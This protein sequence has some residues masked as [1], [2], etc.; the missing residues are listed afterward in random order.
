M[1]TTKV[2]GPPGSG[3]TTFLL[4]IVET[5]LAGG[6]R[7]MEIGYFA[8]TKKAATEARDRAIEKFPALNP[9]T[10]FPF[11][12]TLHSLAYRCLGISTKDMMSTEHYREFALEAGIELAIENGDE[13]FAVKADHP[14]LNEINIARIRGMDLKTH[15]NLSKMDIEWYHF[16]YV[17]R[18]YRHYKTSRN[19]LDFTDLLEHALLNPERLPRLEMTIIDEAQDLS[20]LQWRLVEALAKRS[21]RMFL[22][23]DDDQCQPA[24][25]KVLTT[26][27]EVSIEALDPKR[28]R[29]ICYDRRGSYVVG[30]KAGYAFKVAQ[31][32][33]TGRLY[34]VSSNQNQSSYTENHRCLVRWRP[35]LDVA[36]LRVVYLM[37]KGRHFRIGQCQ[38]FRADGCV[39]AWVRAHLE[40]AEKMWFLKVVRTTE[41]AFFW[42]NH[43]SYLYGIPQTVFKGASSSWQGVVD[44]LHKS[45]ETTGPASRMLADLGLCEQYPLY[46]RQ[47]ISAR[48]GGSQIFE[49]RACNLLPEAMLLASHEDWSVTWGT[50]ELHVGRYIGK[51]Y[52]LDVDKHH[53]YFAD[54][55]L[56][57]NCIYSW[58]G[59]DV[60]S[61][62]NFSGTVKVLD[63]SF[64]VPSK[65]HA[66]ANTVVTRIKQRQPK[67]WKAREEVGSISYYN[68]YSQVDI[69]HGNWLILA[70]ANYML[71]DMHD[72]I[73]SQGLLFERQGQRSVSENI[74]VAVLGWEKLRKGGEVPYPVVKMVYKYLDGEL[75]KH[76]HKM[77]RTA[78]TTIS[79]TL[80]LLKEK[81]G[82]L[83]SEIWHKVLTKISADRRDYLISLLRR[84]TRL[85]GHVPIKLSTI[86]GAKGGEADNVLLLSDLSTRF[87]KDYDKNS[88]DINR[89]L[90]V[91]ITRAKQTLHI[92]LPK[93]EQKGFRL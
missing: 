24:G 92:V 27:G 30:R 84:N 68:D 76:G 9:D 93:N 89:L 71:T 14:I 69:S 46:D 20:R 56:T 75:I 65:I 50:F 52:S 17:E 26:E 87:A 47:E 74:L 15:Y 44:T 33:Y 23:G 43:L 12:R 61:F 55:I 37:Q 79:Y 57:N 86:H 45:L 90:Y 16:E 48:R 54:G 67:V 7:P 29:L 59:A 11:F 1:N 4:S 53:N 2:F 49:V 39:H 21:S 10:D 66:L 41:E 77:L 62:L 88:D 72:W 40:K 78:D 83:S 36:D 63:Q 81:H 25:T 13:E 82:L 73:K 28:H 64:R 6:V 34:Q 38:L 91:G 51:V 35:Y 18:A 3:K 19:L 85:T 5:E 58:A 42:E 31:R 70:S 60:A 8:F 80:D 32:P 22:A